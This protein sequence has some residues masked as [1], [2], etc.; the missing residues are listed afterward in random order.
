V[1]SVAPCDCTQQN[2]AAG[3]H[4]G[5]HSHAPVPLGRR[6]FLS[7]V[8]LPAGA[9][10]L[11]QV[12]PRLPA[13]AGSP[14]PAERAIPCGA[15]GIPRP[16]GRVAPGA[17]AIP[18]GASAGVERRASASSPGVAKSVPAASRGGAPSRCCRPRDGSW[19]SPPPGRGGRSARGAA[20]CEP[21]CPAGCCCA[22]C[23]GAGA[24]WVCC[25]GWWLRS[26][27]SAGSGPS[28]PSFLLK[29]W[30]ATRSSSIGKSGPP[31]WH[32]AL[33]DHFMQ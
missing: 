26:S 9:A 6:T 27:P 17:A 11:P 24:A 2:R 25:G 3:R 16:G 20:K 21:P 31:T 1:R 18:R 30:K 29:F 12:R 7:L 15:P 5:L 4:A 14:A 13:V 8:R 28:L 33:R 22:P 19:G 23:R 32:R 10:A